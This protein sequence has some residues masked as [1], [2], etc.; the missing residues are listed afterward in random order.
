MGGKDPKKPQ[1][2]QAMKE[3]VRWDGTQGPSTTNSG[4]LRMPEFCG[5]DDSAASK[6][7]QRLNARL[8]G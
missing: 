3:Y 4:T 6:S 1:R 8:A 5:R 2:S 7:L